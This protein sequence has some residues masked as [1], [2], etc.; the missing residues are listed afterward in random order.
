MDRS[1]AMIEEDGLESTLREQVIDLWEE[2]ESKFDSDRKKKQ[3]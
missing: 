2:I 3:R 1:I